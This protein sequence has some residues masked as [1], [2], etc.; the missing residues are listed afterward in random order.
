MLCQLRW[1]TSPVRQNVAA[2]AGKDRAL[3]RVFIRRTRGEILRQLKN[4]FIELVATEQF[5]HQGGSYY[6]TLGAK[7]AAG[8]E[9]TDDS[10][11]KKRLRTHE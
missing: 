9:C 4:A 1:L 11:L 7:R 2:V 5:H 3:A 8:D 6:A 10:D